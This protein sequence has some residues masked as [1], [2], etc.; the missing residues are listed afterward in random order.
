MTE[1]FGPG[2]KG[3]GEGAVSGMDS[4]TG[5][6][7]GTGAQEDIKQNANT[8]KVSVKRRRSIII[9]IVPNHRLGS[10]AIGSQN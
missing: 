1:L 7:T 3:V 2:W 10:I 8:Y 4:T 5:T 6:E 9:M